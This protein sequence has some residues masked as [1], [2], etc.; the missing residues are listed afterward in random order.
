MLGTEKN[1]CTIKLQAGLAASLCSLLLERTTC[2]SDLDICRHFLRNN[3]EL[4][5]IPVLKEF[6]MR[7]VMILTNVIFK[8]YCA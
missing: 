2:Y 1:T 6:P 7:S 5:N 3:H 4:D 8:K